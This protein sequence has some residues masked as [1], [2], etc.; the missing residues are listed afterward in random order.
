VK[1]GS[2][3]PRTYVPAF[4][5]LT[6]VYWAAAVTG[7]QWSVVP[8]AGTAVW[9]GAGIAFAGLVLGGVRLWP[10]IVI[11]RVLAA[12][13]VDSPQPLWADLLIAVGTTLG[14]V[15]PVYLLRRLRLFEPSLGRMRDVFWLGLVGGGLGALVSAS[16]GT[17]AV[18]LSGT[19]NGRVGEAWLN[20]WFGF[21]VGVLV[22]AP[23]ILAWRPGAGWRL[24]AR[25]WLHLAACLATIAVVS[26]TVFLL[27][28]S[29][30]LR[31]WHIYPAFIWAAVAFQVRGVS[32]G[33]AITS[34]AAIW[35]A[36]EGTGPLAFPDLAAPTK[37]LVAQQFIAVTALTNLFLAT[38]INERRSVEAQARLAAIVSS[39]P[40][41][42]ISIAPDGHI[43]SW[44][45]GA[46]RLFGYTAAEAVGRRFDLVVPPDLPDGHGPIFPPA[47]AGETIETETIRVGKDGRPKQVAMTASQMRAPDGR[48]LGVAAVVRDITERKRTEAALHESRDRQQ[49]LIHE[50]NHRVKNSLAIVQAIAQQSFRGENATP[51]ARASFEGRLTAL[52]AAHDILTQESWETASIGKV[53]ADALAPYRGQQKRFEIDGPDVR[54]P[55]KTA[56]SLA[57]ALHELSTNAVKY[58]ALSNQ[59]G[60]VEV[61]WA[62]EPEGRSQ[63]LRLVW[64]ERGGPA[65]S[66]PAKRGFGS[67]LIERSLAAEFGGEVKIEFPP[68]GVVCTV[69]APLPEGNNEVQPVPER[70]E[71]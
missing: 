23:L 33:L 25:R 34:V 10:A 62:V 18:W 37:V 38:A 29:P 6:L 24:P 26:G 21:A 69:L 50:L 35:G 58:G 1:R 71:A 5:T 44:N 61:R 52:S 42:M 14:A 17:L 2:I 20:W 15:I 12:L 11:G 66:A 32:A 43:V 46:E 36:I 49:L 40:D 65:V 64:Q 3:E 16:I 39:S 7:L 56:V 70:A 45:S 59:E 19:G 30:F 22:V 63:R 31:V 48:V 51:E 4:L 60:C 27:P 53:V 68:E 47:L 67:R 54:L 28:S 41:A 13:T 8:G 9:P 55:P 57:L